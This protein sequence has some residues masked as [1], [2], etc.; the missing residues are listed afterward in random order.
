MEPGYYWFKHDT[1]A[2]MAGA[3]ARGIP[4]DDPEVAEALR[5]QL[6]DEM[7]WQVVRVDR[8]GL[9]WCFGIGA[10]DMEAQFQLTRALAGPD[11]GFDQHGLHFSRIRG[12]NQ[13]AHSSVNT[14]IVDAIP[15]SIGSNANRNRMPVV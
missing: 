11:C 4:L 8:N 3:Q 15:P 14:M 5:E 2:V 7:A 12:E 13:R 10:A 1:E 6:A 9:V